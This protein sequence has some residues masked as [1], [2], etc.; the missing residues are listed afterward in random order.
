MA[1]HHNQ[2]RLFS[3]EN[4][5]STD[6]IKKTHNFECCSSIT[7]GKGESYNTLCNLNLYAAWIFSITTKPL[8]YLK[9]NKTN[10]KQTE[11]KNPTKK[12]ITS[13]IPVHYGAHGIS[14]S[15]FLPMQRRY[16]NVGSRRKISYLE[17]TKL[18]LCSRSSSVGTSHAQWPQR[19]LRH[20]TSW[21]LGLGP[22]NTFFPLSST[23][24]FY[25]ASKVF[26]NL[27]RGREQYA[28]SSLPENHTSDSW[29][30]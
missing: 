24:Q 1:N 2:P 17:P 26:W 4:S 25:S 12:K 10:P 22:A 15:L 8:S 5:T 21:W 6:E 14:Q 3:L 23:L 19:E 7:P 18:G 16:W 20:I 27:Q 13:Y 30:V 28:Q 11:N 9:T 29:G